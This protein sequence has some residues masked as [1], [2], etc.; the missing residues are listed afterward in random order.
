MKTAVAS[1][2][3]GYLPGPAPDPMLLAALASDIAPLRPSRPDVF[4]AA[5]V[6]ARAGQPVD[7]AHLGTSVGTVPELLLELAGIKAAIR[8]WYDKQPDEVLRESS[9]YSA[10][11]TEIWT[12]L[13]LLETRGLREYTQMRTMQVQPV[14]DEIDRQHK[15]SVSRIAMM[16]QDIDMATRGGGA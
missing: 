13:R 7:W 11:L 3:P 16:R 15:L 12:E 4:E 8:T 5:A 14:L 9:A 10:R 1:T 2:D 6:A